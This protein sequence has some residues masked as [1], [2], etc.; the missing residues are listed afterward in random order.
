MPKGQC[1]QYTEAQREFIRLNSALPHQELT[2]MFNQEFGTALSR[3]A[4]SAYCKRYGFLTGRTGC[5]EKGAKPWNTG[6]KGAVKPNSGCFKPGVKPKNFKPVGHERICSKDG[7]V[8]IKTDQVNPYTGAST[9]YRFKHLVVWEQ[10]HGPVPK[11]HI[12]RF[13]D[14]DKTNCELS[15]LECVSQAVNLR[16]N[17]NEVAKL[18]AELMETGRLISK[19]EVAA[20]QASRKG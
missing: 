3:P 8:L 18:P 13:K 10:A 17:Q 20:F 19:L 9:S 14:G 15:N 16:M 1:H 6:T 4:I 12:L 11:G 5:F 7:Y 2:D